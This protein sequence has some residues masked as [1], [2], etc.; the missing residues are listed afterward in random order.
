MDIKPV[1][2][3][4]DDIKKDDSDT[5]VVIKDYTFGA[6]LRQKNKEEQAKM[7][8]EKYNVLYSFLPKKF[9]I[10][11]GNN[12]LQQYSIKA[13]AITDP[14]GEKEQ[15]IKEEKRENKSDSKSLIQ[16]FYKKIL[17]KSN[18]ESLNALRIFLDE[19][20]SSALLDMDNYYSKL[21]NDILF[22]HFHLMEYLRIF[23]FVFLVERDTIYENFLQEILV[24]IRGFNLDNYAIRTNH[25]FKVRF[26]IL[27]YNL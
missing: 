11:K 7:D 25:L 24:K 5:K 6:R 21:L 12:E 4:P 20:I 10:Y 1:E 13:F 19:E 15:E 3:S 27:C 16:E 9:D 18:Q 8:E 22:K 17:R 26:R 2:E 23:K 14:V